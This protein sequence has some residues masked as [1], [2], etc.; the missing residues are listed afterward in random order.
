MT[1]R[2]PLAGY[3]RWQ[4]QDS[5]LRAFTPVILFA[6]MGGI[7]L[8]S[9]T[10]TVG[11]GA[12]DQPGE[13]QSL[14]LQIYGSTMPL[15][16]TLG[17]VI[18]ATGIPATDREKQYFRFL[19]AKPVVAWEFYLQQFL[20]AL[21]LF[22]AAMTLVPV[23]ISAIVTPVP[24]L[25]VTQSALL[26]GL[27]YGSLVVLCGALV[28]KDGVAFIAV[29]ALSFM[30]QSL[31][32]AGALP[33][34]LALVASGLPPFVV[35]DGMRAQW[36][37]GQPVPLGDIIHVTGYSIGMLAAALYFVRRLPLARS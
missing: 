17:A 9:F 3:L 7:P 30:L 21:V 16:M 19:F 27:L 32:K 25:A 2:G 12:M 1:G 18:L 37:A 26:F 35:A 6:G 5:L 4:A 33:D 24:V 15:A 28:N 31:G 36:L 14:A 23:G 20:V 11:L 34:W 13:A 8:W 29:A 10:R 22:A